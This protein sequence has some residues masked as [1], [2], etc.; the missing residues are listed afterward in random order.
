MAE[1]KEEM[2]KGVKDLV[3]WASNVRLEEIP[4][5]ALRRAVL[6]IADDLAAMVASRKETEVVSILEHIFR[7][8]TREEATLFCGGRRRTDRFSAAIGNAMAANWSELDEGYR[9]A[10]CHAGL[11]TLPAL[12][13]EAEAE[14]K[15]VGEVLRA[16]VISYEVITRIARGWA[17]Y[18][19]ILHPHADLAAVGAASA[20]ASLRHLNV[21]DF[22]NAL[23]SSATLVVIG[24]FNHGVKGAL[25]R[26]MWAASGAWHGMMSVD[27]ALC[28]I[29]GLGSTFYDVYTTALGGTMHPEQL[30]SNLG[31]EWAIRDGYHKIFA[32]CQYGHSAVEAALSIAAD[33]PPG[34]TSQDIKRVVVETHARGLTL[35]NH[36][37]ETTLAS[38][39]SMSHIVAATIV[40]GHAGVE[41]FGSLALRKPEIVELRSKIELRPFLPEQEW[42]NDRPARVTVELKNGVVLT[43][44]CM[45]AKGG[46]DRPFTEEEILRKVTQITSDVYPDLAPSLTE[47][48]ALTSEKK[49]ERWD[50]LV[51]RLIGGKES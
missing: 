20:I 26:N 32:C 11:Y 40:F 43:R 33:M 22:F 48:L 42:P 29:G 17:I 46:P 19:L 10:T 37:P 36:N 2:E 18:P 41:A 4:E 1:L 35:D 34:K 23:T 38:K 47:F 14:A 3:Q 31:G 50:T 45:S 13:A 28:G 12:L 51:G 16:A 25:V 8:T 7:N 44:E 9:K 49:A 27:W 21:K 15:T 24:P 6:I 5:A 30:T 39:F